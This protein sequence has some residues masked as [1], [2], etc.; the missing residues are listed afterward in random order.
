MARAGR[1]RRDTGR[2][3]VAGAPV[4]SLRRRLCEEVVAAVTDHQAEVDRLLAEYH[5]SREQLARVHRELAAICVSEDS[6][7]GTITATVGAQGRLTGLR[8]DPDAYRRHRP[9]ELAELVV[10]LASAAAG[11]AAERAR[12]VLEPVLP[13]GTDAGAV[14]AGTADLRPAELVEIVEPAPGRD[15]EESLEHRS[16]LERAHR[17]RR[18]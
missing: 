13:A 8:I 4:Q 2:N 18:A 16:W 11:Q 7:D 17:R 1:V 5:R 9:A 12:T 6:P 10:A 3:R 14:L 15:A